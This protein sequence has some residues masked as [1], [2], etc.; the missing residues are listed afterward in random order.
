MTNKEWEEMKAAFSMIDEPLSDRTMYVYGL[1][2]TKS[3]EDNKAACDAWADK[4]ENDIVAA[5]Q[6]RADR[7]RAA[8]RELPLQKTAVERWRAAREEVEL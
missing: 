8:G 3:D 5:W 1:Q 7:I 6:A 4:I 2:L